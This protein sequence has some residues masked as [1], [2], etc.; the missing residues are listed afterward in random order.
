MKKILNRVTVTG[1]DDSIQ[2]EELVAMSKRFPWV[3]WGILFSDSK[4]S[5]FTDHVNIPSPPAW[6]RYPTL[7]WLQKL[8]DLNP[9]I[10]L[11]AHLCGKYVREACKGNW[12]WMEKNPG[13]EQLFGRIQLNFAHMRHED[14]KGLR[15]ALSDFRV[16]SAM[17]AEPGK[18]VIFGCRDA[19]N[20]IKQ[21]FRHPVEFDVAPL[22]DASG[23]K[24]LLGSWPEHP[25]FYCGYAGGLSPENLGEQLEVLSNVVGDNIVWIDVESKVRSMDDLVFDMNK[26]EEFLKVA[27]PWVE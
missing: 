5:N 7:V 13:I 9:K 15:T 23:G 4:Q 16:I 12:F 24:G 18:Q 25:G 6:P 17:K 27:E 21:E 1:A 20:I 8:I 14:F 19:S 26:V 10:N 3:E 2:P 11:S 22:F